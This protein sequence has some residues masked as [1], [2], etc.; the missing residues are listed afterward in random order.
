L[1]LYP[2]V[3]DKDRMQLLME[4]GNKGVGTVAA[5]TFQEL[6]GRKI[7]WKEGEEEIKERMLILLHNNGLEQNKETVKEELQLKMKPLAAISN[8]V[9]FIDDNQVEG[10]IEKLREM[11]KPSDDVIEIFNRMGEEFKQSS[12]VL[13]LTQDLNYLEGLVVK[14]EDELEPEEKKILQEYL[15]KVRGQMVKLQSVFEKIEQKFTNYNKSQKSAE[16]NPL[17]QSKLVEIDRII[18]AR[19]LKKFISSTMTTHMNTIIENMR[20]CLSCTRQGCN[21]DTD[22]TFGDLNKFYLYSQTETQERGS[23]SDQIVFLVPIKTEQG[24]EEMSFVLDR[25]YGNTTPAILINHI[26]AVVQKMNKIKE[27]FPNIK[28]S[29]CVSAEASNKAGIRTEELSSKLAELL[30][31]GFSITSENV[32][33]DIAES[34]AADHYIEFGEKGARDSGERSVSGLVISQK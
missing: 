23:I 19:D 7:E 17:L 18:Q 5:K 30:E 26:Q 24:L 12:G 2:D 14:R 29:V 33:V 22:L 1:D 10:E 28:L 6:S 3:V 20:E 13:A 11:Q 15:L 16:N 4:V 31:G 27:K 25:P 32:E 21:N 34:A 9:N 8:L